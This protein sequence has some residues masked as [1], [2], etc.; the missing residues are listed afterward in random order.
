MSKRN[1]GSGGLRKRGKTWQASLSLPP[2]PGTGARTRKTFTGATKKEAV[3]RRRAFQ[4]RVDVGLDVVG[5]QSLLGEYFERWLRDHAARS[6]SARTLA[7]YEQTGRMLVALIGSVR[8]SDLRPSHLERAITTYLQS[9]ASNR[10]AAKH[11]TVLKAALSRAVLL[12]LI[13]RNPAA[14]VTKPRA[15]RREMRV[16]DMET[17]AAILDACTDPDLRRLINLAVHTGLRAGELLGLRWADISWDHSLLQVKR[18]R[19]DFAVSGFAEPK[20]AAGRRAIALSGREKEILR[21]H[22]AAQGERRLS[23][24]PAWPN[25]DL[26]F[27]RS[28]GMPENV[29]NLARRWRD[30]CRRAGVVGLR[31]HDLRHTS[32]T[33]ALASGVHPK[34]VQ[35]RLGHTTISVTLDTYSHVLPSM[36]EEAATRIEETM[37]VLDRRSRPRPA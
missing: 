6:V 12:E 10:T 20:T 25:N 37:S 34:I 31:F 19:N 30:L 14:A 32:A 36:Q 1:Y 24:G 2:D 35:E 22:R 29:A 3:G 18:A 7:G 13:P 16:A 33:I 23:L 28:D 27:P 21:E 26:V 5:A 11:L 4:Q 9:G 8:L 17:L 15:T